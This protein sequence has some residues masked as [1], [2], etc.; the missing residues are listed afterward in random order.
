MFDHPAISDLLAAAMLGVA[1]YCV[2]RLVLSFSGARVTERSTDVVHA[3]MG[4]S[5]A[6][7][8][9]PS[10]S[11]LPTTVWVVLF[12]GSALWFGWGVFQD[13]VVIR[14]QPFGSHLPHLLMCVAMMY[15]L[16]AMDWSGSGHSSGTSNMSMSGL[17]GHGTTWP[18][19]A[20]ALTAIL[21]SDV[22]LNAAVTLRRLAPTSSLPVRALAMAQSGL[23]EID[24]RGSSGGTH[25]D[26]HVALGGPNSHG[27][28]LAPRSAVLCQL[29]MCLVMGYM[30][31]SMS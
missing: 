15:M 5:M 9:V 31:V 11:A 13:S 21:V 18:L 17:S 27:H 12:S 7:M 16:V 4:I 2:T 19:L 24:I 8:L 3:V 30:L 28:L 22:A 20:F 10:L 25:R 6:G 1:L 26:E 14:R 29:V 23:D